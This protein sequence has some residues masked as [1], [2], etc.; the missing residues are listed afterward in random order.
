MKYKVIKRNRS[1][2]PV[3]KMCR[4]LKVSGSGF[5]K[6]LKREE[7][8]SFSDAALK[9][10]IKTI[11]KKSR[12]TYGYLRI[13]KSLRSMGF[14]IN[15]KK[16]SRLMREMDISG[17]QTRRFRPKTTLSQ[18][19]Y[20]ITPNLVRRNFLPERRNQVWASD[21]TYIQI[22]NTWVYLCV[23]IDLASREVVGWSL[24]NHMRV[25]LVLKATQSALKYR[26]LE[27]VKELIF[28][29]DRGSQYASNTFQKYLKDIGART[30][31]SGKGN[32]YDNAVSDLGGNL[33]QCRV[34]R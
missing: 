29:S 6:W 7:N 22:N 4:I 33:R 34:M 13:T 25:E 8:P 18:H 24:E 3:K 32:C 15:K 16:V 2:Y 27:N 1:R 5:H 26:G 23:V 20:P 30:S 31:M 17:L 28:H 21:I 12:E 14:I 9:V 11:H 19:N 10:H